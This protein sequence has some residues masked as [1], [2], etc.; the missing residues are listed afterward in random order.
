MKYILLQKH[1]P[2]FIITKKLNQYPKIEAQTSDE[3]QA[4]EN[5]ENSTIVFNYMLLSK[6]ASNIHQFSTRRRHNQIYV[7]Y[8]SQSYFH[9][10]KNNICKKSYKNIS[11]IQTLRDIILL[12]HDTAGLDMNTQEWK[13][14]SGE[15]WEE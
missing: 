15:V 7:Y 9:L 1:E 2:I 10:T 12:F 13:I 4:L 5:S 6:Q 3:I 8:L 11:F 14:L